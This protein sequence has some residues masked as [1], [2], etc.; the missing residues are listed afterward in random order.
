MSK[1]LVQSLTLV[2]T[3]VLALPSC[4]CCLLPLQSAQASPLPA[5]AACC[6]HD[7]TEPAQSTCS[8]CGKPNN[9]AS[10]AQKAPLTKVCCCSTPLS[11][12]PDGVAPSPPDLTAILVIPDAIVSLD[13]GITV[14]QLDDFFSLSYPL[15]LFQ[16]VWRC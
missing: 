15:H 13:E 8:C 11:T 7:S 5:S 3:F 10:P 9:P 6:C 16:C 14:Q 2:C 12:P 1:L 4:W